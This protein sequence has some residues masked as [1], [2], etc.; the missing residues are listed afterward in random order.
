MRADTAIWAGLG[1]Y[2][3]VRFFR[4]V[5]RENHRLSAETY[6]FTFPMLPEAFDRTRF[7]FL[8]DLHNNC[9]GERNEE[10]LAAI[11]RADPEFVLI[12]GDM[13]ISRQPRYNDRTKEF[14]CR[15]AAEYPIYYTNGNHEENYRKA[16]R[17]GREAHRRY[18]RDLKRAGVRFLHNEVIYLEK[19]GAR[20]AIAGFEPPH[21]CYQKGRVRKMGGEVMNRLLG[22]PEAFT[23]LLAHTP[24][25]FENYADWGAGLVL[26]GHV[27]GGMIR[28]PLLGGV[29]S[30]QYTLFPKYDA[31]VYTRGG[32]TMLLSRGLGLHTLPIRVWNR[33]ELSVV[34]LR[35]ARG[36]GK[37][38]N[39]NTG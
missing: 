22:K 3:A 10:L 14:L 16:T 17:E 12:G 4:Y 29:A 15:L 25:Y 32:S 24:F 34:C 33:P 27:H 20:I 39:G 26:S 9:F 11:R 35:R 36:E 37:E 1:A 8:T 30:P 6:Q 2:G 38:R 28:L 19:Q 18:E 31:G 5:R 13:I 7:V 23:I 21:L